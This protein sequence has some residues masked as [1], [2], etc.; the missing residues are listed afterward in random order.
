GRRARD[1]LPA[2][3]RDPGRPVLTAMTWSDNE[4]VPT[5]VLGASEERAHASYPIFEFPRPAMG[6][7][8][9]VPR[10]VSR[11]NLYRQLRGKLQ[12]PMLRAEDMEPCERS[13]VD[14]RVDHR[15]DGEPKV[16]QFTV[17]P[18]ADEVGRIELVL[19]RRVGNVG[20][21]LGWDHHG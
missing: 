14:A 11:P 7:G 12:L 10:G 2:R 1:P 6:R 21:L 13:L 18:R 19:E 15:R 20:A 3:S 4:Q 8:G 9:A 17:R 5:L 16:W